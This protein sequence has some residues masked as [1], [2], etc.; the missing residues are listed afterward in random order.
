MPKVI[1]FTKP[2][3]LNEDVQLEFAGPVLDDQ[4]REF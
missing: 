1:P 4:S 3:V 2:Q